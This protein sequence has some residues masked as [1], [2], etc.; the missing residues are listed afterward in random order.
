MIRSV[1]CKGDVATGWR[2]GGSA[3]VY[4]VVSCSKMAAAAQS[5]AVYEAPT[6][7]GRYPWYSNPRISATTL[8][9]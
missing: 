3:E 9:N 6:L 2:R 8:L 1:F 4:V 5:G 7:G